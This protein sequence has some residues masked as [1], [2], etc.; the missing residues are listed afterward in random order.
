MAQEFGGDWTQTKLAAVEAYLTGYLTVMKNQGFRKIYVDGFAG[1]GAASAES[2]APLPG[3]EELEDFYRG[4]VQRALELDAPFDEY[5]FIEQRQTHARTLE[6]RIQEM[7]VARN[8]QI[9]VGDANSFL[10]AW[11]PTLGRSDRALVFLD[12][13]G[14]SVEWKTI[15]ILA[16]TKK[17]DLWYLIPVG[18]GFMRMLPRNEFPPSEWADKITLVLGTNDWRDTWYASRTDSNLFE[19]DVIEPEKR[20]VDFEGIQ[21]YMIARLESVFAGVVKDPIILRNSTGNPMYI[22]CF[23]V[24]NPAGVRPALNIAGHIAR[25]FNGN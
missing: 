16:A 17:I 21:R 6:R 15:E 10:Q 5:I 12:P 18:M 25:K 23:G 13:Y 3:M 1:S 19:D 20:L 22:L 8:F 24:G 2:D 9:E 7:G 11:A 14:M 4:S